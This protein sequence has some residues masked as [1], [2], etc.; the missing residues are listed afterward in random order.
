MEIP[1]R[2]SIV[3]L[4][5]ADLARSEAFYSAL[6]WR[7]AS[8]SVPGEITWF[9]TVGSWIGLFDWAALAE[10]A[11]AEPVR[12]TGFDGITL[13]INVE[14]EQQVDVALTVAKRAGASIVQPAAQMDWGGYR[15]YFADPDGH[16]WE[17]AYNPAFPIDRDGR[18]VIP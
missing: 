5:V 18:V 4:G 17:V 15:G 7:R 16:R 11:G 9:E 12:R 14:T 8:S 1:A 6:G 10:D 13:A 2:L 3:T